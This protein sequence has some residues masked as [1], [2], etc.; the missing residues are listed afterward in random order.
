MKMTSHLLY[1]VVV[2]AVSAKRILHH[3]FDYLELQPKKHLLYTA[4]QYNFFFLIFR[5]FRFAAYRQ[6]TFWIHSKLG[7]RV[8]RVV[9]SCVTIRIRN[10]YPAPDGIYTEYQEV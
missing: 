10:E 7:K 2:Y 9:P 3:T 8:R 4:V 5:T 1:T 6:F